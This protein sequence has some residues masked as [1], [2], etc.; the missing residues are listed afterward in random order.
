MEV[1]VADHIWEGYAFDCDIVSL[2]LGD[3]ILPRHLA[4]HRQRDL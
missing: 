4:G 1:R 3:L 2:E